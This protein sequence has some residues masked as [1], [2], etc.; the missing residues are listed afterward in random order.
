MKCVKLLYG[1]RRKQQ[2]DIWY[3]SPNKTK[4]NENTLNKFETIL[5]CNSIENQKRKNLD[6]FIE[7]NINEN[8][9]KFVLNSATKAKNE[10]KLIETKDKF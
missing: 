7:L 5:L 10:F 4:I 8:T 6:V 3:A 9:S 2:T 1:T